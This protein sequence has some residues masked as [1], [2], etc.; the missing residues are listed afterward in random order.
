[1]SGKEKAKGEILNRSWIVVRDRIQDDGFEIATVA[2]Q[3][4]NDDKG[5]KEI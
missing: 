5:G 1:M 3:P 4:H 2:S